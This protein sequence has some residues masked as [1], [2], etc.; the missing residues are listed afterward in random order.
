MHDVVCTYDCGANFPAFIHPNGML[1]DL[2]LLEP[3]GCTLSYQPEQLRTI[4]IPADHIAKAEHSI[5]QGFV[6]VLP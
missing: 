3:D 6:L 2:R 4:G 5:P 1:V